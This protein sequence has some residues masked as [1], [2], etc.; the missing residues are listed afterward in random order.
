V[1]PQAELVN[2]RGTL[3]GTTSAG[4][5]SRNC[6]SGGCGTVF[7]IT[8]G[9]IEK[10]LYSFGSSPD[11]YWPEAGLIDV[12]GT[13]YGTTAFGGSNRNC[14]L[15]ISTLQAIRAGRRPHEKNCM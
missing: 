12:G 5:S 8:P 1:I 6:G 4:G 11:G 14:G 15:G 13:L 7:S 3:Y 9:G 2:V 10:V